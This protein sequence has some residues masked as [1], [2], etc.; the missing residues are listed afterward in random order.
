MVRYALCFSV[1][2]INSQLT[3]RSSPSYAG[4]TRYILFMLPLSK[5]AHC[6]FL[7]D[8]VMLMSTTTND[9]KREIY[10]RFD[11]MVSGRGEDI[12]LCYITVRM[13]TS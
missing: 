1:L 11:N 13:R 12:K 7:V 4:R 8:A 9:E 5:M 2:K 10:R 6:E 3:G